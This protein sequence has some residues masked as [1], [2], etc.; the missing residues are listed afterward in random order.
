MELGDEGFQKYNRPQTFDWD[1]L[2]EKSYAY[3]DV[4]IHEE[5]S[6]K[7]VFELADEF[8]PITTLNFKRLCENKSLAHKGGYLDTTLHRIIKGNAVMGGDVEMLD[9][10]G[11]HSSFQSRYMMDEGFFI[12]HDKR[13]ILSMASIGERERERDRITHKT[14]TYGGVFY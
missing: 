9:G 6:K 11:G 3:F 12:P 4:S 7:M 5:I 14:C 8:L 1:I 10:E 13:G 2:N